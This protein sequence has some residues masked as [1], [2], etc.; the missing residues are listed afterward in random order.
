MISSRF[1]EGEPRR[2][3]GTKGRSELAMDADET[4]KRVYVDFMKHGGSVVFLTALGTLRD[5][6][7]QGIELREGLRLRLYQDDSDGA[8][9]PG[10]LHAEGDVFQSD[11]RGKRCWA[12][13]LIGPI[14]FAPS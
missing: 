5:L 1:G 14:E 2:R 4:V 6:D 13:R 3:Q 10:Y 9:R 8:G 12:A 11:D 7:R